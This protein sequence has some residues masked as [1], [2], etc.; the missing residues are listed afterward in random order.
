[1]YIIIIF[2]VFIF[3]I[4]KSLD[5]LLYANDIIEYLAEKFSTEPKC[6]HYLDGML[7]LCLMPPTLNFVTECSNN[8]P[9]LIR[10]YDVMGDNI[11]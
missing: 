2:C 6:T 4:L 11:I 8:L 1:M 7:T 5:H 9:I 10:F 3:Y